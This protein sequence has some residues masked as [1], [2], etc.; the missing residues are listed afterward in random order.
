M[1]KIQYVMDVVKRRKRWRDFRK[2]KPRN[3]ARGNA[4]SKLLVKNTT[5]SKQV[6]ASF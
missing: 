2:F 1:S 5:Y 4:A 6:R 3:G